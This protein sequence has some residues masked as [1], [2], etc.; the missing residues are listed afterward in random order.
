MFGRTQHPQP[1]GHI[2]ATRQLRRR[3][4][5][6]AQCGA[7]RSFANPQ[8]SRDGASVVA[9]LVFLHEPRGRYGRVLEVGLGPP[10][11]YHLVGVVGDEGGEE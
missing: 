6:V 5:D 9:V 8:C 4:P 10:L 7:G 2:L 1:V 11:W 3:R